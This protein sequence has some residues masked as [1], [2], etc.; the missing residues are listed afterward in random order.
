M[1]RPRMTTLAV[2]LAF[3]SSTAKTPI[4]LSNPT[5]ASA[6]TAKECDRCMLLVRRVQIVEVSNSCKL[7]LKLLQ[8]L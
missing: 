7:W 8:K 1:K 2:Q 5:D 4:V 3:T 6:D